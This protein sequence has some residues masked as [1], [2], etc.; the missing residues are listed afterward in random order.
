MRILNLKKKIAIA[1]IL[2]QLILAFIVY[3]NRTVNLFSNP[4]LYNNIDE[5]EECKVALLLGTSK[6]LRNGYENQFFKF[7]ILAA[8]ELYESGKI[9]FILVSGDNGNST[10]NEPLDMKNELMKNGIPENCIYLDYAGFRTYDSVVRC[11]EIFG[12]KK[13][14]VASQKFHNQRAIYLARKLGYE[15]YGYNAADVTAYST[16]RTD[17]REFFARAKAY[18]DV[19]LGFKPKFLGPKIEIK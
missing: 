14:I 11:Y 4:Y 16:I 2:A 13:F 6:Q 8:K 10:Y 7:R 9:K 19:I 5:I 3:A 1:F 17:I 15:A 18:I 12:Q